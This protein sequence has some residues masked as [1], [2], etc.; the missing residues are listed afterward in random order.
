[1]IYQ[2]AYG[3]FA[4][5]WKDHLDYSFFVNHVTSLV[6]ALT[7]GN[8]KLF[9]YHSDDEKLLMEFNL[10][11]NVKWNL[12]KYTKCKLKKMKSNFETCSHV[13]RH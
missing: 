4:G 6:G 9:I 7:V 5:Q 2:S 12:K 3:V 11:K 13:K 8:R 10:E 1:M